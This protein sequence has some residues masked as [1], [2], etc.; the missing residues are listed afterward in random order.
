MASADEGQLV[1]AEEA[2]R[3]IQQCRYHED[4]LADLESVFDWSR[5]K[6]PKNEQFANGFS[7]TSN[8]PLQS[9]RRPLVAVI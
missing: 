1:S 2:W 7:T 8:L 9:R 3:R 5:E 6:L 4:A